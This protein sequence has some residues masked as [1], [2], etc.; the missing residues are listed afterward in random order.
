[1]DDREIG[2]LIADR[3]NELGEWS[4]PPHVGHISGEPDF[5]RGMFTVT[6]FSK[7]TATQVAVL[8]DEE[9]ASPGWFDLVRSRLGLPGEDAR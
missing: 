9:L 6:Y 4:Q 5:E 8:S 2:E 1:M 7:H 3:Q